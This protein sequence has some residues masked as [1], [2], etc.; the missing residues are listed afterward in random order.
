MF[1]TEI[2]YSITNMLEKFENSVTK[3]ADKEINPKVELEKILVKYKRCSLVDIPDD[4]LSAIGYEKIIKK[5]VDQEDV[6]T[7][8]PIGYS[9]KKQEEHESKLAEKI[10]HTPFG[11]IEVFLSK[12]EIS[13]RRLSPAEFKALE[14]RIREIE[15][16]AEL[17]NLELYVE[18]EYFER[19]V[20]EYK[21]SPLAF[22]RDNF[23]EFIESSKV[24]FGAD[25]NN[26]SFDIFSS[27]SLLSLITWGV[28]NFSERIREMS[29]YDRDEHGEIFLSAQKALNYFELLEKSKGFFSDLPAFERIWQEHLNYPYLE[30]HDYDRKESPQIFNYCRKNNLVTCQDV[31]VNLFATYLEGKHLPEVAKEVRDAK[32]IKEINNLLI[33]EQKN[34]PRDWVEK[35]KRLKERIKQ[36]TIEEKKELSSQLKDIQETKEGR[37]K[38]L[39]G[40]EQFFSSPAIAVQF[41][42]RIIKELQDC[43]VHKGDKVEVDFYLDASVDAKYDK[44]PGQVSGD[45]TKGM[46]L[47]FLESNYAYNVKV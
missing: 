17:P 37:K 26:L 8:K 44:D 36:A 29:D 39:L 14:T 46:P 30:M 11:P 32:N 20:S 31:I 40:L 43:L 12:K 34:L 19:M 47:P 4:E 33:T 15:Y 21:G 35:E 41:F 28:N 7:I 5:I 25:R 9:Q 18:N 16:L 23:L 3:Q 2:C 6:V 38:I 1:D 45:C 22:L 10:R 24:N 13:S 27:D 42:N